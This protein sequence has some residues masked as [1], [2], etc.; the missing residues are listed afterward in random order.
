WYQIILTIGIRKH[1]VNI[2]FSPYYKLPLFAP[3]PCIS[4]IFDLMYLTFEPY[5]RRLSLFEKAYYYT[6]GKIYAL[7]SAAILTC[8]RYS[9]A[10][11][12]NT[13]HVKAQKIQVTGLGVAAH[14]MPLQKGEDLKSYLAPWKIGGR[15]ALYFGTA[16]EHK[17]LEGL[18]RAFGTLADEFP[19]VQLVVAGKIDPEQL[20]VKAELDTCANRAAIVFTGLVAHSQQRAL[21]C[22]ASLVVVPSFYEGWGYPACEA[23]ACGAPVVASAATSLPEVVGDAALMVD[24]AR[25]E[26]IAAAM[27]TLLRSPQLC[28]DM[29]NRGLDRARN[30]SSQKTAENWYELFLKTTG[31]KM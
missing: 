31:R 21:Y 12:I 9:C 10:E 20:S 24:A 30:F 19:D 26:S 25:P 16:K 4:T 2:F 7:K 11:I 17:N 18:L 28:L 3:V 1:G 29:R 13:Y 22:L 14:L 6:F 27:R 5:K 23:M 15:F 8:S